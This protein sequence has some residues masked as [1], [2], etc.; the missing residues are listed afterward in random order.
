MGD[1]SNSSSR[2]CLCP[3]IPKLLTTI[4]EQLN[5]PVNKMLIIFTTLTM[6]NNNSTEIRQLRKFSTKAEVNTLITNITLYT[7]LLLKNNSH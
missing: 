7:A 6:S 2:E 4:T 3:I 1:W 5:L